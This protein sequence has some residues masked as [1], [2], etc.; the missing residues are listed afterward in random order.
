MS[1]NSEWVCLAGLSGVIAHI[2]SEKCGLMKRSQVRD[3]AT[4]LSC[5]QIT[6][7]KF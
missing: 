1:D 4:P 6:G 2:E 3:M 5:L 7:T